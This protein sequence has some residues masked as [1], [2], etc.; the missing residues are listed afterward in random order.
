M[1]PAITVAI[2][3]VVLS[4][5]MGIYFYPQ[6]PPELDT[7]WGAD[8]EAN[9]QGSKFTA[10]FAIPIVSVILLVLFLVIPKIDPKKENIKKFKGS[11]EALVFVIVAFMF[12]LYILY[13]LWNLGADFNFTLLLLP[14]FTLL[15]LFMG[16][17]LEKAEPNWFVG[18]RTP[19]TLSSENVWHKTHKLGAKLFKIAALITLFGFVFQG[20]AIWFVVVPVIAFALYLVVYS[21]VEY[22][23]EKP[24][25]G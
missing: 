6:M 16:F 2:V 1:R 4:F 3:L 9:G 21:Y 22:R 12:Y 8:G 13:L 5:L 7:H 18:I 14:A 15:F 19:W 20:L 10:L 24:K 25:K 11:Y 23:K 17:V